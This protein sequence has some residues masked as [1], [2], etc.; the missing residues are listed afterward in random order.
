MV[1]AIKAQ[2]K[3]GA[4][5]KA[6][7][8]IELSMMLDNDIRSAHKDDHFRVRYNPQMAKDIETVITDSVR[9]QQYR[10][11]LKSMQEKNFFFVKAEIL[12]GNIGYLRW[13]GFTGMED[14][15]APVFKNA[16]RLMEHTKALII[17]MRYNG[18][19]SLPEHRQGIYRS[20]SYL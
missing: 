5:N 18:G 4:Y 14:A 6:K 12:P 11:S 2:F 1:N 15:A 19:G 13:D 3:A 7:D 17:D 10:I 20:D 9:A 8:R 16:F